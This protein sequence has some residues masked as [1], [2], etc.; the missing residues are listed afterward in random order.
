M[1]NYSNEKA[2]VEYVALLIKE[3]IEEINNPNR[4]TRSERREY[5]ELIE[6]GVAFLIRK[7]RCTFGSDFK[8]YLKDTLIKIRIDVFDYLCNVNPSDYRMSLI[9]EKLVRVTR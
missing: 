4:I 2:R 9:Y 7:Y 1:K 8:H 5:F 6:E 3:H